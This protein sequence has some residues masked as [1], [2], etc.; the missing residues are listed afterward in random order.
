MLEN[1]WL[2]AAWAFV[3]RQLPAPPATV[4][5][6]GCGSLGGFV[7]ELIAHGYDAVG[8]DPHA[9]EGSSY[10]QVTFEDAELPRPAHAVIASASLH[11]V[12]DLGQIADRIAAALHPAGTLV[13]VEWAWERVDEATANW[14]FARLGAATDRT[15]QGWLRRHQERWSSSGQ[16]WDTYF[17][18]WAKDER[19][20]P[21]ERIIEALDARFERRAISEGPYFFSDLDDTSE[22]DEQS[23]IDA[24]EIQPTC[25][26]YVATRRST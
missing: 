15:G 25:V 21:S 8:V 16:P 3:G 10:R 19:L 18:Q 5:E 26:R 4:V 2:S 12:H 13:V 20:H 9:P 7:P 24:G 6:I 22:A 23:A 14:C 11:H 17:Q 1:R